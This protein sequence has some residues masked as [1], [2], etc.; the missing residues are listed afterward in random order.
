MKWLLLGF[1]LC[2][3]PVEANK[4]GWECSEHRATGKGITVATEPECRATAREGAAVEAA[5]R[6]DGE[7]VRGLVRYFLVSY[8]TPTKPLKGA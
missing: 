4:S 1:T 3:Q 8:C 2:I 7:R 5:K 6:M